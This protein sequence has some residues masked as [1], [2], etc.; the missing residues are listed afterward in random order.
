MLYTSNFA[1]TKFITSMEIV[2]ISI[3]RRPPSWWTGLDYI[4]LAPSAELLQLYK[5][6]G[7]T[8]FYTN[9]FN[10]QLDKLNSKEV[11]KELVALAGQSDIALL[12][13][14][15]P[16]NFC[17]RHLVADWFNNNGI[18]IQEIKHGTTSR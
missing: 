4:K 5:F 10:K 3:A 9:E 8:E 16:N 12:C 11:Y 1:K 14:E 7:D 15:S 17:H 13:Y 18:P 6:L 2:P